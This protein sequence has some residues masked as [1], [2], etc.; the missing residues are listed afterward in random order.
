MALETAEESCNADSTIKQQI[1]EHNLGDDYLQKMCVWERVK[2]D[3]PCM[4]SPV[5]QV[6][7]GREFEHKEIKRK[8]A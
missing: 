4:E 5:E 8:K 3:Q 6:N 1:L 2:D 7:C